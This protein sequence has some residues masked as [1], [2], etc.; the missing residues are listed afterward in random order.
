MTYHDR[1][2]RLPAKRPHLDTGALELKAGTIGLR[3][4]TLRTVRPSIRPVWVHYF[5]GRGRPQNLGFFGLD[6]Q[7]ERHP[8]VRSAIQNFQRQILSLSS[9]EANS[10][11]K[12]DGRKRNVRMDYKGRERINV[13]SD[14]DLT[15]IGNATLDCR[16]DISL[17]VNCAERLMEVEAA[18]LLSLQDAFADVRDLRSEIPGNQEIPPGRGFRLVYDWLVRFRQPSRPV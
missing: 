10:I 13:L 3:E 17:R 15:L 12:A 6:R 4:A 11:C 1:N 14:R 5:L 16:A 7:F 2:T 9:S 8:R 18:M